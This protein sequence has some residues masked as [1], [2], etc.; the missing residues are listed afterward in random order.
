MSTAGVFVA[1]HD[2]RI[3]PPL[4]KA[5]RPNVPRL[6]AVRRLLEQTHGAKAC[7]QALSLVRTWPTLYG[8]NLMVVAPAAAEGMPRAAVLEYDCRTDLEG[9]CT[10]RIVN[11][12]TAEGKD[13]VPALCLAC[14][15]HHR[16][17]EAPEGYSELYKRWRFPV[18]ASPEAATEAPPFDV[19]GLFAHVSKAA[20]PSK[21]VQR[22]A[23]GLK[24]DARAHGTLH[25][26]VGEPER[27]RLH[28]RLGKLGRH[29][30]DAPTRVYDVAALV[31]GAH[32]PR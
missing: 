32:A 24:G 1:V 10:L 20:F 9:G 5:F 15:N 13:E 2:V 28:I 11:S 19:A 29:I 3:K 21:G 12:E 7:V 22:L 8:N 27:G 31:R 4:D 17:R 16:G 30:T 25:Q 6:L 14:T 23:T 18:L 26:A